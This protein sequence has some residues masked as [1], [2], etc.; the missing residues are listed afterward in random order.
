MADE[1][2]TL[3]NSS[4]GAA[5][6]IR[7][8]MAEFRDSTQEALTNMQVCSEFATQSTQSARDASERF[9]E[10][11]VHTNDILALNQQIA[12]ATEEQSSVVDELNHTLQSLNDGI[13]RV[14]G[15]ARE[16][17]AASEHLRKL[18]DQLKVGGSQF[19]V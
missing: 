4:Q 5:T 6:K 2:R 16:A 1:V 3:A 8:L 14:T 9:H 15:K 18:A 17:S 13:H 10:T 11:A 12:T 7:D 19:K